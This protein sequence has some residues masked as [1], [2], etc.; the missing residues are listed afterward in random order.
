MRLTFCI[1]L[2][3][4]RGI[5]GDVDPC[6]PRSG[7]D[8]GQLQF[9]TSPT[10][11]SFHRSLSLNSSH[12]PLNVPK[13]SISVKRS[14]HFHD[15]DSRFSDAPSYGESDHSL[16]ARLDRMMDSVI[17]QAVA[18][19]AGPRKSGSMTLDVPEPSAQ[20]YTAKRF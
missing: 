17:D 8:Q 2:D 18:V 4:E 1:D 15:G 6:P 19:G 11:P 20:R 5:D 14:T 13:R 9:T 7:H 16:S 3:C 10:S 12:L